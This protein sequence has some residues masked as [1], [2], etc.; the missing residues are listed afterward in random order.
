MQTACNKVLNGEPRLS[1]AVRPGRGE[2]PR[3][4]DLEYS[5]MTARPVTLEGFRARRRFVAARRPEEID[6]LD[7]T[8]VVEML[9]ESDA[10]RVGATG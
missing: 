6:S 2:T 7:V 4:S 9:M 5:I 8:T 3:A 1:A 10:E